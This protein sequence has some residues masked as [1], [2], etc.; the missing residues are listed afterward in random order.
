[1]YLLF[2]SQIIIYNSNN[3]EVQCHDPWLIGLIG[4]YYQMS[5]KNNSSVAESSFGRNKEVT[6]DGMEAV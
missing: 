2:F 5:T 6:I 1:M 4:Y 3:K